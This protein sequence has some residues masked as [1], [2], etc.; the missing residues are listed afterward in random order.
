MMVMDLKDVIVGIVL[1]VLAFLKP[2]E[3]E[4]WS[5]TIVFGLNFLFGYLNDMIEHGADFSMKKAIACIGHAMIFFML[6]LAIYG[7]GKLKGEEARAM[8][9]V[10]FFSYLIIYFYG[11]NVLRNCKG[12][13]RKGTTP[14]HVVSALYFMLRFE[15]VKMVPGLKAYF[16]SVEHSKL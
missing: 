16:S 14:W 7:I 8:Q 15:F 1:A 6:C 5:L 10:S 11:C 4:L 9:C 12:M 2:L 13:L 3:G